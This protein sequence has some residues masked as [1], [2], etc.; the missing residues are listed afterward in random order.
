[1]GPGNLIINN[2]EEDH[3]K[4]LLFLSNI[5][6]ASSSPSLGTIFF[7]IISRKAPRCSDL[8]SSHI[9]YVFRAS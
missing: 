6:S 5:F 2:P 7:L 9:I 3:E 1:M 8:L 4:N